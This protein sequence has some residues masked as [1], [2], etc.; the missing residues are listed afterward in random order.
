MEK[1]LEFLRK[2]G[3]EVLHPQG[4]V[5]GSPQPTLDLI[6]TIILRFQVIIKNWPK[7]FIFD[8]DYNL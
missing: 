2:K 5:D 4:I 1:A 3:V 6:W 7:K 8:Y